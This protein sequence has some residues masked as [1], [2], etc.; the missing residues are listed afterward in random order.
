MLDVKKAIITIDA[1]GCQKEIA[2]RSE[3]EGADF[4]F[5]LKDNSANLHGEVRDILHEGLESEFAGMK[6]QECET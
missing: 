6:H 3:D 4:V 1:M 2:A 5:S